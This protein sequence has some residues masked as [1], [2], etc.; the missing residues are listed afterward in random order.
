[1]LDS[2]KLKQPIFYQQAFVP[3]SKNIVLHAYFIEINDVF[4]DKAKDYIEFFIQYLFRLKN[5]DLSDEKLANLLKN[6]SYPDFIEIFPINGVIKKDQL[7]SVMDQFSNS[8]FY[9]GYQIYVVYEAEKLNHH[10]ANTILKF[11]EEPSS[12]IIAIF[13]ATNRYQI[14]NT[15]LSRCQVLSLKHEMLDVDFESFGEDELEFFEAIHSGDNQLLLF[16]NK[17]YENL[18]STRQQAVITINHAKIY[19]KYEFEKNQDYSNMRLLEIIHILDECLFR[20]KY[21]VNLKLWLDN[22]L[23]QLMEVDL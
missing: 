3:A 8:S 12:N 15:I 17:Y 6:K 19:L 23:L 16:F 14:I 21:N 11:L 13:V 2:I 1:M 10:A 7:L 5:E 9:N 22:M 18:F 20:L 4:F